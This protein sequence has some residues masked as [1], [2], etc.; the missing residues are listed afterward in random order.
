MFQDLR[1][2]LEREVEEA[3]RFGRGFGEDGGSGGARFGGRGRRWRCDGCGC[4]GRGGLCRRRHFL[5]RQLE[6][7][8]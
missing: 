5:N 4:I 6:R 3:E 8:E 7:S 1:D 2:Q